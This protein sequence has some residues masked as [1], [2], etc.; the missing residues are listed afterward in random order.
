M[1]EICQADPNSKQSQKLIGALSASLLTLSGTPAFEYFNESEFNDEKAIF[2]LAK[3][4]GIAIACGGFRYLQ[5]GTCEIKRVYSH[6][7]G[8]GKWVLKELE[9]LALI[10][11]YQHINLAT[12]KSNTQAVQFYLKHGYHFTAPFGP[13]VHHKHYVSFAKTATAVQQ[14]LSTKKAQLNYCA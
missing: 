1:I 14:Q 5:P 7:R 4:N 8:V 9:I 10:K 6:Q 11:G 3:R 2:L 13:Y 12:R